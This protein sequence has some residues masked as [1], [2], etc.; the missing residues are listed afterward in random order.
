[1]NVVGCRW[2]Y[3]IKHRSDGSIDRYKACL[4]AKRFHQ[5]QVVDF[6]NTFSP[7]VKPA[8]IRT[9]LTVAISRGWSLQQLDVKNAFL[10]SI[11]QEEVHMQQPP[12]SYA[13]STC[14]SS[15]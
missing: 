15:L 11:L 5:Q 2:V 1:M 13:A 4:V 14:M 9:V 10:H 3:C 12:G 6:S 7:V 8:T